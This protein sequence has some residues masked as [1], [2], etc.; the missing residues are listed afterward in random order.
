M[1]R[2]L[3]LFDGFYNLSSYK[4]IFACLND[5][6]TF[7]ALFTAAGIT[8]VLADDYYMNFR[9]GEKLLNRTFERILEKRFN[10]TVGNAALKLVADM[11]ILSEHEKYNRM[12][13]I[14]MSEYNPIENYDR[15]EDLQKDYSSS[16]GSTEEATNRDT[17]TETIVDQI[18]GF[19]SSTF[20]DSNKST[21]TDDLTH[22][23]DVDRTHELE[24]EETNT[25]HI[26]GNIGVTTADQMLNGYKDFWSE[27]N[28]LEMVSQDIDDI[29]TTNSY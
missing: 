10:G 24:G 9:S 3:D 22:T 6:N 19:N 12:L 13:D 11:I 14:I 20:Q 2:I 17:G 5:N 21:K 26:H 29:I 16:G 23:A 8:P 1:K 27:F 18:E 4:G 28:I 7:N 15:Y 25:N